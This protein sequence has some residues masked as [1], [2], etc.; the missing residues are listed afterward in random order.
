MCRGWLLNDL[1]FERA[2]AVANAL[3]CENR[4]L[5]FFDMAVQIFTLD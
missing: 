3:K 2:Y 5:H 1:R 4:R